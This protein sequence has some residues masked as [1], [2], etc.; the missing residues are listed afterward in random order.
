MSSRDRGRRN[1]EALIAAARVVFEER[2]RHAPLS[3]VAKRAGVGQGSLYR[4]FPDRTSL[5]VAVFEENV[6][7]IEALGHDPAATLSDVL[8]LVTHQTTA[9]A[10]FVETITLEPADARLEQFVHRLRNVLEKKWAQAAA[11]GQV[12]ADTSVEDLMLA[13]RM[14]ALSV[15]HA[16]PEKRRAMAQRAWELLA[17]G[18]G[19]I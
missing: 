13:V 8:D 10:A 19:R 15:S 4:H 6:A 16:P 7:Q 11:V 18:L 12:A 9:A 3:A 1:R 17:P 2:G 14:V 5:A